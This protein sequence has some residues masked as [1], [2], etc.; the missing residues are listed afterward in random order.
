M[1]YQEQI[2]TIKGG[3]ENPTIRNGQVLI[4]CD[5]QTIEVPALVAEGVG[6]AIHQ[7]V[8]EDGLHEDAYAITHIVSGLRIGGPLTSEDEAKRVLELI[9]PL[10]DWNRPADAVWQHRRIVQR[11]WREAHY[12]TH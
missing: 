4:P 8:H 6:L 9:A 10:L 1:K 5:Y 7:E 2:I 12:A 11:A 3:F